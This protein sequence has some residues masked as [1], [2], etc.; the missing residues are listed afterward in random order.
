MELLKQRGTREKRRP[1]RTVHVWL[2][3]AMVHNL[4]ALDHPRLN[5]YIK[6]NV[7][8]DHPRQVR[9]EQRGGGNHAFKTNSASGEMDGLSLHTPSFP[10][11]FSNALDVRTVVA[12]FDIHHLKLSRAELLCA[13]LHA[14]VA[15]AGAGRLLG[16][17]LGVHNL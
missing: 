2:A 14:A 9:G 8:R 4:L 3:L 17:G 7:F 15:L 16:H 10:F 13:H 5:F 11:Q 1:M 6:F 12:N